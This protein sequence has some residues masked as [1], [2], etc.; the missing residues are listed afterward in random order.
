QR[1]AISPPERRG[2]HMAVHRERDVAAGDAFE[3]RDEGIVQQKADAE[4]PEDLRVR[5][6]EGDRHGDELENAV[7]LWQQADA[8][9]AGQRVAH[10]RLARYDERTAAL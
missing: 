7:R 8:L 3:L 5:L 9:A 6:V 1:G 10:R 2:E 4:R